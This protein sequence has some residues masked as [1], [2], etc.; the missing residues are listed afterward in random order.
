MIGFHI[1]F[2]LFSSLSLSLS[3]S[4]SDR[5]IVFEVSFLFPLVWFLI[6]W[7]KWPKSRRRKKR[8]IL[9]LLLLC[10]DPVWCLI[11]ACHLLLI[12]LRFSGFNKVIFV[13]SYWERESTRRKFFVFFFLLLLLPLPMMKRIAQIGYVFFLPLSLPPWKN[14][15]PI[16]FCPSFFCLQYFLLFHSFSINFYLAIVEEF[17]SD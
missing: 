9:L 5:I 4:L 12:L 6:I 10:D 11:K 3:L 7:M 2:F 16:I 15:T 1:A 14:S 17:D 13:S 8:E